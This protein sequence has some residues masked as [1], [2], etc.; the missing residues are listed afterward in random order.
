MEDKRGCRD[1]E[2][3]YLPLHTVDILR[4]SAFQLINSPTNFGLL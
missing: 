3:G 2:N 4:E 1:V